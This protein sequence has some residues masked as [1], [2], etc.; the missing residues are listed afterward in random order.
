MSESPSPQAQQALPDDDLAFAVLHNDL[1]AL[2]TQRKARNLLDDEIALSKVQT[3]HPS[4]HALLDDLRR[5]QDKAAQISLYRSA[6]APVQKIP[7]EILATIFLHF[8]DIVPFPIPYQSYRGEW[9]LPLV[10]KK[11]H[12]VFWGT[13]ELWS[14]LVFTFSATLERSGESSLRVTLSHC[15]GPLGL[16]HLDCFVPHL[17]RTS[18][19]SVDTPAIAPDFYFSSP[20]LVKSLRSLDIR[21][22]PGN[23]DFGSLQTAQHLR[24]VSLYAFPASSLSALSQLPLSQLTTLHLVATP[25]F[26][27]HVFDILAHS[28]NLVECSFCLGN[29]D[30]GEA[31][32]PPAPLEPLKHNLHSLNLYT[33]EGFDQEGTSVQRL[34][35]P[36]LRHFKFYP[37]IDQWDAR[38]API[39]IRSGLLETLLLKAAPISSPDLEELLRGAPNLVELSLMKAYSSRCKTI[40][41][42]VLQD[43]GSGVLV[44]KLERL[45][46]TINID[47]DGLAAL[48]QHLDMLERRRAAFGVQHIERVRFVFVLEGIY[49]GGFKPGRLQKMQLEGWDIEYDIVYSAYITIPAPP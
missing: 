23:C 26:A 19:L 28:P 30:P 24:A 41:A 11:W 46:C 33:Y 44:P 22:I 2:S 25:F 45:V 17:H 34:W 12:Q 5:R 43:M 32:A 21:W 31:G 18:H 29:G 13:P 9:N 6:I 48:D 35:L 7:I 16:E 27:T 37:D 8:F 14:N 20:E 36:Q 39:I 4:S 40:A 49:S 10:C 15:G 47:T 42:E 38:L 3:P 1:L